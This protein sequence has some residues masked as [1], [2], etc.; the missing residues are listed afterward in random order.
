VQGYPGRSRHGGLGWSS[1]ALL[2][3]DDRGVLVDTGGF[4]VHPLLARRLAEHGV[5]PG[6]RDRR[7]GDP[8]AL[9]PPR[10]LPALPGGGDLDQ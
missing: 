10:E 4:G 5:A 7:P 3:G 9:R 1:I 2:I 8:L 6:R